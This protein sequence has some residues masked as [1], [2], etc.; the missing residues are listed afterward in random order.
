MS[1]RDECQ[2]WIG[3]EICGH[4][5]S[6]HRPYAYKRDGI[7]SASAIASLLD[8]GKADTMP[9]ASSGIA[10]HT[11][12]HVPEVMEY[13][14]GPCDHDTKEFCDRCRFVRAQFKKEWD[15]KTKLG[16]HIH[17]IFGDWAERGEPDFDATYDAQSAPYL[18]A[19]ASFWEEKK[20]EFDPNLIE[21]TVENT[22]P[23]QEYR[24]QFDAIGI[25]EWE[26]FRKTGLI[27]VKTTT[28]VYFPEDT[29]Q[30]A[31]YRYAEFLTTYEDKKVVDRQPMPEVEFTAILWLRPD[32]EYRLVDMPT[33]RTDFDSFLAMRALWTWQRE[34]NERK[35]AWEKEEAA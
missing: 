34:I 29:A 15:D 9:W 21:R 33:T 19:L 5:L 24:G 32:G 18:D 11:A 35:K 6:G 12:V 20:P 1:K 3:G 7:P 25:M 17:H 28:G 13:A 30:L 27:D 2:L 4:D 16:T 14:T 23:G 31:G 22:V 26:A 10:A 8:A